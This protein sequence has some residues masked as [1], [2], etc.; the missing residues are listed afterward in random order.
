[1]Y[2]YIMSRDNIIVKARIKNPSK[3][4]RIFIL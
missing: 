2:Y 1:M 4:A 3:I